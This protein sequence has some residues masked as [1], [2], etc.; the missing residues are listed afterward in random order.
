MLVRACIVLICGAGLLAGQSD[1]AEA[2]KNPFAGQA[3]AIAAGKTLYSAQCQRCHA[4]GIANFQRGA[5]DGE[6][7]LNIRNGIRNTAMQA[8]TQL[9]T[10]QI[11]QVVSYMR[12]L[13]AGTSP[14][15]TTSASGKSVFEGKGGCLACHQFNGK[16]TPVGPDLTFTALSA[17]QI[18]AFITNPN[19]PAAGG[20]GRGRG[21]GGFGR[22]GGAARATVTATAADGKV[23]KG[24]RKS[25]DSFT[26][27]MVDT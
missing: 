8:F 17:D 16:G 26:I 10:D 15:T 1:R 25:Q 21:R 18:Q 24:T 4:Q 14:V 5:E 20:G 7:F 2:A 13:N 23:Y 3:S 19:A 27:Q 22:G 6:I 9:S 11:W 12:T